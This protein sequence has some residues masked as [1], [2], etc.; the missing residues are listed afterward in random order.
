MDTTCTKNTIAIETR[1]D[2]E[3]P[4][5]ETSILIEPLERDASGRITQFQ[6]DA[7]LDAAK[8]DG[9]YIL[10]SE[11]SIYMMAASV[12]REYCYCLQRYTYYLKEYQKGDPPAAGLYTKYQYYRSRLEDLMT[13]MEFMEKVQLKEEKSNKTE[14]MSAPQ[15]S[16]SSQAF[17]VETFQGS[18]ISSAQ[19]REKMA[20]LDNEVKLRQDRL[21]YSMEKNRYA[22]NSLALYTFLNLTAVGILLY[23]FKK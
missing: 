2:A 12:Q 15:E 16:Y 3:T 6:F 19:L 20:D 9:R 8:K 17:P 5:T 21:E 22:T 18:L 14:M 11:Y 13:V 23:L 1:N 10:G 4:F 7:L